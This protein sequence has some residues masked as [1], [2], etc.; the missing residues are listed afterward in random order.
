MDV[1]QIA[2]HGSTII[3]V[4]A[5]IVNIIFIFMIRNGMRSAV[6]QVYKN[7]MTCFAAC[8]ITFASVEFMV[9]PGIHI[10]GTSL[11]TYSHGIFG[12]AK[13]WGFLSLCL[14]IG[15]YGVNTALLALHFVYRYIFLCRQRLLSIFDGAATIAVVT[16]SVLSWGFV[17]GLITFYCFDAT[18]D[19]YKYASPSVYAKLGID[20]HSL[21]F[22]CIFTH[23]VNGDTTTIHWNSAVGLSMIYAM[24]IVTFSIMTVCGI[25]MNQTLKKSSMSQQSKALQTQ[26]LKALVVQ[27]LTPFIFSY[28]SRVVMYTSV[29]LGI[30]PLRIYQFMPL[31]V[32]SYTVIDPIAIMFFVCDFRRN[33]KKCVR[34][35]LC[36][37]KNFQ[38]QS[39]ATPSQRTPVFFKTNGAVSGIAAAEHAKTV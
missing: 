28:L 30:Q 24:M 26:L 31:V 34:V 18:E 19:Y 3:F 6:G 8:N 37:R 29:V 25:K 14:F 11:M 38:V 39:V 1:Q 35:R 10:Y 15:M 21:S 5:A 27:A 23:E 33:L 9:K 36:A 20:A 2:A 17:Y 13:P 7:I 22:F 4:L 16:L 32:T 12:T